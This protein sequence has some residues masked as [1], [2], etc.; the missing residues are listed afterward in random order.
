M[1]NGLVHKAELAR[2][3]P[4]SWALLPL[5]GAVLLAGAIP[6]VIELG[7]AVYGVRG[8]NPSWTCTATKV[9]TLDLSDWIRR[10]KARAQSTNPQSRHH[11]FPLCTGPP[12]WHLDF[13][14]ASRLLFG[15]PLRVF[16]SF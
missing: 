9:Q 13:T 14:A 16:G 4:G 15:P 2:I 12:A 5:S 3:S 7:L 1:T 8:R 11:I 6:T 10:S